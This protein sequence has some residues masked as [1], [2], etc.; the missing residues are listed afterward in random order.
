MLI[1]LLPEQASAHWDDIKTAVKESL[2][3]TVGEQ[4]D[5]MNNILN[6]LL[7]ERMIAWISVEQRGEDNIIT[8]IVLTTFTQDECSGTK[9]LLIYCVYGYNN[10]TRVSWE[11]GIETLRKFAESSGCH[12][13][14]AYSDVESI[15]KFV[16]GIGGETKYRLLSFPL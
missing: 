13:I 1:R 10:A 4:S 5:K 14:L 8:G 7:T 6:G 15:I 11:S 2:P 9:A 16:E 12:R 3:P